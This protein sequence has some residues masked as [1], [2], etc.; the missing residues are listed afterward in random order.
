MHDLR[1][2][3]F[4]PDH[5]DSDMRVRRTIECMAGAFARVDVFWDR[6]YPGHRFHEWAAESNVSEHYV[7][8]R[9]LRRVR[10]LV[11]VPA[12][13]RA[14]TEAIVEAD[15]VYIHAS[16][17]EGLLY[18]RQARRWNAD[19][20][21]VFD[22]HDSLSYELFY[23]LKKRGL[24]ALFGFLWSI[25]R[26]PLRQF[27]RAVDA[28]VGISPNQVEDLKRLTGREFD[29]AIV[30][31]V[32]DF[33]DA[34]VPHLATKWSDE[35]SLV[36]LGQV[37]RGRDLERLADWTRG[38]HRN[39]WLHVF[40]KVID[41]R[42]EAAVREVLGNRVVFYGQYQADEGIA[43]TL[44]PNPIGVFLGWEDPFNTG[45][46]RIASPNKYFSYINL[47][48]PMILDASLEGLAREIREWQAGLAIGSRSDFAAAVDRILIDYPK[49]VSGVRKLKAFYRALAP[50]EV[51][52]EFLRDISRRSQ[53]RSRAGLKKTHGTFENPHEGEPPQLGAATEGAGR[54]DSTTMI[55]S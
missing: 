11:G 55:E 42:A 50:D 36:W 47:E 27:A 41:P 3:I 49:Y 51:L 5:A 16:G 21:I 31:N 9:R 35:I 8:R 7:E 37:M 23:Q 53:A 40:G 52:W 33:T 25:Y 32:R 18:A 6:Q 13:G 20:T 12:L 29:A 19:S 2:V 4:A 39:A 17:I 24:Q 34:A 44:P 22:Y 45:I 28:V 15:V 14:I 10:S 30:P 48:L 54:A 1:A 43:R 26:F 38:L 46:N